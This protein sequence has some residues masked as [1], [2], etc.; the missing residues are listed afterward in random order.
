MPL[1]KTGSVDILLMF[2]YLN[3]E[4]EHKVRKDNKTLYSLKKNKVKLRILKYIL[5]KEIKTVLCGSLF[6]LGQ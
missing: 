6:Q 3:I 5:R 1:K 4:V 2:I